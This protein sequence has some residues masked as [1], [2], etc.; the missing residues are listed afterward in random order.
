MEEEPLRL[1]PPR[2]PEEELRPRLALLRLLDPPRL[3]LALRDAP[4]LTE[5]ALRLRLLPPRELFDCDDLAMMF[6][7]FGSRGCPPRF[8][9]ASLL[10]RSR[11]R[12]RES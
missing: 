7:Y 2:L 12:S 8:A 3:L 1:W 4:L 9:F 5:L 6:S 11:R 10:R